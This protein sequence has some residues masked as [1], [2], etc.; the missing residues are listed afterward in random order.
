VNEPEVLRRTKR[1]LPGRQI[2]YAFVL[3]KSL[4]TDLLAAIYRLAAD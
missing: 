4:G 1:G 3:K 2:A